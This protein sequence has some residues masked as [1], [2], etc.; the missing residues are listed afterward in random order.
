MRLL[1]GREPVRRTQKYLEAGKLVL[2]DRVRVVSINYNGT[3]ENHQGARLKMRYF[4]LEHRDFIFW[5]LPQLQF[6]NPNVQMVTFKDLTPTPFIK[7]YLEGNEQVLMDVD[8]Y[9]K[10][11]IH[12]RFKRIICKSDDLLQREASSLQRQ[13]NPANFG[14]NCPRHCICE[15]PGQVPCPGLIPLPKHMRGKYKYQGYED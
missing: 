7:L 1:V 3:G 5:H 14:S 9:T 4:C 2:K 8:G 11:Q 12:E 10:E 15:I 13:D 6:K